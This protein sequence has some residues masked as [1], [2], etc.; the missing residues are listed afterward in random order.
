[1]VTPAERDEPDAKSRGRFLLVTWR[2]GGNVPAFIALTRLLC[3]RG[4]EVRI[5][6]PQTIAQQ[7]QAHGA[8]LVPLPKALEWDDS[9]GRGLEDQVEL[10]V[11]IMV[12]ESLAELVLK[13]AAWADVV[14][15]DCVLQNAMAAAQA[16]GRCQA[17]LVHVLYQPWA[18][19]RRPG[20]L[21]NELERR[22]NK[23]RA[24]L[25]VAAL[26]KKYG[27]AELWSRPERTLV[28]VPESFDAPGRKP[29]AN[30]RYVGPL[31]EF[32]AEKVDLPWDKDDSR[33]LVL[34]SLSSIYQHQEDLLGRILAAVDPVATRVLLTLGNGLSLDE[35]E[36]PAGVVTRQWLPHAAIMG[37]VQVIITHAGL[38]T[39]S[40]ALAEGVPLLCL[41]LGA[42]QPNN[43]ARVQAVDAGLML[44][45]QA[46]PDE[47][48]S[49]LS[50]LLASDRYRVGAGRMAD[51]IAGYGRGA[52][53]VAELEELLAEAKG[54]RVATPASQSW[55]RR[56]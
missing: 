27:F 7:V 14:I 56:R 25:G 53:A 28:L 9:K 23:M 47:I 44:D 33:A 34:I 43:A 35:V 4:H 18:S 16:A 37:E 24:S 41:P 36:V 32:D 42:D 19:K 13:E 20:G 15:N 12:G 10:C 2:G 11:E 39:V 49:A 3:A 55:F 5:I 6:G 52:Q 29:T 54:R 48:R 8:E 51:A 21:W 31:L 38:S 1:M 17:A 46:R 45:P 40:Q 22:G 30:V 50:K 26:P